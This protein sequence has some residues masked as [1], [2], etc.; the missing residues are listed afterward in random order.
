MLPWDDIHNIFN[1]LLNIITFNYHSEIKVVIAN[2]CGLKPSISLV[3]H[4]YNA[5][6]Y[7][8]VFID[9]QGDTDIDYYTAYSIYTKVFVYT[10]LSLKA[11]ASI[12]EGV[13]RSQTKGLTLPRTFRPRGQNFRPTLDHPHCSSFII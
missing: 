6:F 10:W 1:R 4:K 5:M 9:V 2:L 7:L 11:I 3:K 12:W 13:D 8:S